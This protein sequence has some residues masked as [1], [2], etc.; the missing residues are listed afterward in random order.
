MKKLYMIEFGN[1]RVESYGGMN[2]EIVF[3]LAESYDE[4][5]YLSQNKKKIN[6]LIDSDGS[7]RSTKNSNNIAYIKM[8]SDEVLGAD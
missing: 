2:A 1:P 7:L 6:N 5:I 4:A 3:V 8:L